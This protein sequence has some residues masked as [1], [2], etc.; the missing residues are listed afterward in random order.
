MHDKESR[1]LKWNK[2]TLCSENQV[3]DPCKILRL[4]TANF[5]FLLSGCTF[6]VKGQMVMKK[7]DFTSLFFDFKVIVQSLLQKK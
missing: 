1:A 6:G 5:I 2:Q 3:S 4:E 7:L